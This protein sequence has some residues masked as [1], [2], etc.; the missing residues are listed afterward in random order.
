MMHHCLAT[1]KT[2]LAVLQKSQGFILLNNK[3]NEIGLEK[4]AILL[5][6]ATDVSVDSF[7]TLECCSA[8]AMMIPA[9]ALHLS[10]GEIYTVLNNVNNNDSENIPLN[11]LLHK[12][13]ESTRILVTGDNSSLLILLHAFLVKLPA[14]YLH[15]TIEKD[16]CTYIEQLFIDQLFTISM[17][18]H[19]KHVLVLAFK[20]IT[21]WVTNA[22]QPIND[23]RNS[24]MI[25]LF[26]SKVIPH[27]LNYVNYPI[28]TIRHN[29]SKALTDSFQFLTN[30]NS[31]HVILELSQ[32]YFKGSIRS[33][34]TI[35]ILKTLSQFVSI[36]QLLLTK[37]NLTSD[38][39]QL[40][41]DVDLSS[42]G[43]DL[44]KVLSEY[45]YQEIKN[46]EML[47]NGWI[48]IWVN[49]T[50]VFLNGENKEIKKGIV[51]YIIPSLLRIYPT[52]VKIYINDITNE[53]CLIKARVAIVLLK[54]YRSLKNNEGKNVIEFQSD[55]RKEMWKSLLPMKY[56]QLFCTHNDEQV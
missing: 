45:H 39:I 26:K 10:K 9:I 50:F 46:N 41:S 15:T 44:Y 20:T 18:S 17:K 14:S 6:L 21:L 52:L 12:V 33:R 19:N 54:S 38:V 5:N 7:M 24:H 47:K 13:I 27:L 37:P 31:K 3:K 30:S 34:G 55:E 16:N 42:H 36:S 25:D 11:V 28:D 51:E 4:L 48:N 53:N 8:A 56:M 40:L 29:V 1:L 49:N 43:C 2:I 35:M 32:H 23:Q 22:T